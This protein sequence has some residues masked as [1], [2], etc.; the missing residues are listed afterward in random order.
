MCVIGSYGMDCIIHGKV[1]KSISRN[2]R[3]SCTDMQMVIDNSE[4]EVMSIVRL[5]GEVQS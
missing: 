5:Q 4:W 3:C 1:Y 2:E